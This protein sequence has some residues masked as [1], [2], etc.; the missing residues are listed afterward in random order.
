[1][2]G[3]DSSLRPPRI[4]KGPR[5]EQHPSPREAKRTEVPCPW[6]LLHVQPV[7]R[8]CHTFLNA[9]GARAANSL[10]LPAHRGAVAQ[11]QIVRDL[12]G[13]MLFVSLYQGSGSIRCPA[14]N[15]LTARVN[16]TSRFIL[17]WQESC[18]GI[19]TKFSCVL[20]EADRY[21]PRSRGTDGS[22]AVI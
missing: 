21:E 12:L 10:T 13:E 4:R 6:V 9:P 15:R 1:M 16:Q 17:N 2:N 11:S 19:V 5:L 14:V 8:I 3:S 18:R 22:R 20:Y 7:A